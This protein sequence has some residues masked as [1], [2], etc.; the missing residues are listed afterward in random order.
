[1]DMYGTYFLIGRYDYTQFTVSVQCLLGKLLRSGFPL[2]SSV[3]R[4][5]IR[6]RIRI[7]LCCVVTIMMPT[8]RFFSQVFRLLFTESQFT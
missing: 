1:M 5:P 6:I 7:L 8:K 2:F 3:F 4:I